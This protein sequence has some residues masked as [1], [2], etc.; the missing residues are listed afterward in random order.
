MAP[1]PVAILG[2][3]ISGVMISNFLEENKL[4]ISLQVTNC[5]TGH[6]YK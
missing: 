5:W 1:I 4:P 2:R 3:S 6:L